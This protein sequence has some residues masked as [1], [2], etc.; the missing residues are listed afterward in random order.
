MIR[1]PPRSTLFPYTTLFRSVIGPLWR[2]VGGSS[3]G[4]IRALD[5]AERDGETGAERR[6]DRGGVACEERDAV[7]RLQ[8]VANGIV[9]QSLG[10][11]RIAGVFVARMSGVSIR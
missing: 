9:D 7:E 6:R 10:A 2:L 5:I 1:R 4:E 3:L 8:I 11:R